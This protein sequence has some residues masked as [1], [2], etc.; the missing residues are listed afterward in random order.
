MVENLI[1]LAAAC[2]IA[3]RGMTLSELRREFTAIQSADYADQHD[4]RLE[5]ALVL[6]RK[7]LSDDTR[8]I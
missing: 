4:V 5:E 8:L 7:H 3:A 1:R 2:G 6:A